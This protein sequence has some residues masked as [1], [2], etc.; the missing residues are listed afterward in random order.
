VR[1]LCSRRL[2]GDASSDHHDPALPEAAV[3][4][5]TTTRTGERRPI[6]GEAFHGDRGSENTATT[7]QLTS[8]RLGVVQPMG[9]AGLALCNAAAQAYHRVGLSTAA[10]SPSKTRPAPTS[11][12]G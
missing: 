7:F 8:Q 4:M 9:L 1:T 2:L 10:R 11:V 3:Q 5:A 6:R 12:R